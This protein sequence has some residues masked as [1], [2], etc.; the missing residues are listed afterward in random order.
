MTRRTSPDT[1][2]VRGSVGSD[3]ARRLGSMEMARETRPDGEVESV[4]IGRLTDQAALSGVL[5]TL[6]EL[7][8]PVVSAECLEA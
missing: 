5:N 7:Y 6:Y 2:R 8:M 3:W 1:I 4:L